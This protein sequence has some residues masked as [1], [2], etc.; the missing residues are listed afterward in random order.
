MSLCM[1]IHGDL[2]SE[3]CE[4]ILLHI[5]DSFG[6]N[7]ECISDDIYARNIILSFNTTLQT[8][9]SRNVIPIPYPVYN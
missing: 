3:K 7:D 1:N 9:E 2:Y 8:L 6:V 5:M 4:W